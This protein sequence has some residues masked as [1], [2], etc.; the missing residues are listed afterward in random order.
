M[1]VLGRRALAFNVVALTLV[2][3]ALPHCGHPPP[4]GS[5]SASSSS[6][7]DTTSPAPTPGKCPDLASSDAIMK[8]DFAASFGV[9]AEAALKLRAGAAAAV[10]L[11]ALAGQID[12]ELRSSCAS[13][14]KDLGAEGD[15][16]DGT[17]ACNLAIKAINDTKAK[18]GAKAQFGLVVKP[19][20]C[21]ADPAAFSECASKCDPK[22]AG[23]QLKIDCD[24][25]KTSGECGG[26][27]EGSCEAK[28][29]VKC[30]GECNGT[31][32]GDVHGQCGGTCKGK[33][34]GKTTGAGAS[35][36]GNCDGKCDAN[37]K[38]VCAGKCSGSC[39]PK[40]KASCD[41]TCTGKC[42]A[43][44]K[45]PKCVGELKAPELSAD[46][47]ADCD[48]KMGTS[49]SCT[50]ATVSLVAI[51]DDKL[52]KDLKAT[53]VKNL[54]AVLRV[55][56]GL[57]DRAAKTALNGK[58]VIEGVQASTAEIAKTSGDATKAAVVSSQIG[59]CLGDTFKN[60]VGSADTLKAN[61]D[62]SVNVQASAAATA[63]P[64]PGTKK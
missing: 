46:C 33:C 12:K 42:D 10:D 5:S 60:A 17:E 23:A 39:A 43:E 15:P 44:I 20:V 31:C 8:Q 9:N 34:D 36:A 4:K 7:A 50:P 22:S 40:A 21:A 25:A 16:K 24:P 51:S 53:L 26:K 29:A 13:I 30:D 32:E 63:G 18:L 28:T 56:M 57:G 2:C 45:S 59:T 1:R 55:S 37:M 3:T 64:P 11:L 47:K 41:G 61:V 27:C 35:C 52:A 14:A 6:S 54:P 19:P 58:A 49:M 48:E 62:V 38:G